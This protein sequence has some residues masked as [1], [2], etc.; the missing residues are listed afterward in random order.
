[1]PF[2]R[3]SSLRFPI[4]SPY[5]SGQVIDQDEADTLNVLRAERIRSSLGKF[6]DRVRGTKAELSPQDLESIFARA[7]ALDAEWT[8]SAYRT[9]RQKKNSFE[10]HLEQVAQ[11]RAEAQARRAGR[12][13]DLTIVRSLFLLEL[14]KPEVREEAERRFEASMQVAQDALDDLLG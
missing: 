9:K 11:A 5:S 7:K 10:F 2:I 8:F 6:I 12:E 3:I 13:T 1:M 14:E 4:S